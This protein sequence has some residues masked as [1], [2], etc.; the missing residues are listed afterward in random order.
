MP[1]G[2]SPGDRLIL[3]VAKHRENATLRKLAHSRMSG[4]V[5]EEAK[6]QTAGLVVFEPIY[7]N[8]RRSRSRPLG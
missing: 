4:A 8:G 1:K 3:M 5:L 7:H 6:R 2:Q